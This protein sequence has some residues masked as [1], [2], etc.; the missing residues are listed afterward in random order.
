RLDMEATE[1]TGIDFETVPHIA[2][3]PRYLYR[4][5]A[6]SALEMARGYLSRDWIRAFEQELWLWFFAGILR[7]RW[8]DNGLARKQLLNTSGADPAPKPIF[9]YLGDLLVF[10]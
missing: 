2:G 1:A 4:T 3:V 10:V 7:Q 5:F 6:G 8:K 9:A